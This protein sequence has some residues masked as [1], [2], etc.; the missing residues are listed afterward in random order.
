MAHALALTALRVQLL[1]HCEVQCER[2]D[3]KGLGNCR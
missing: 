2:G 1:D 3:Q